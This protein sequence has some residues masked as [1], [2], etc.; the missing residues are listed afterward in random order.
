MG[1]GKGAA[2]QT[3]CE[4]AIVHSRSRNPSK[5]RHRSLASNR[6]RCAG[7]ASAEDTRDSAISKLASEDDLGWIPRLLDE[8]IPS[9]KHHQM[10]R[11]VAWPDALL[12]QAFGFSS[13]QEARFPP[14]L[15]SYIR[16]EGN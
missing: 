14:G 2:T 4:L 11:I 8:D 5:S 9:W 6:T 13:V 15:A 7:H 1:A 10:V 12:P 3:A 16:W